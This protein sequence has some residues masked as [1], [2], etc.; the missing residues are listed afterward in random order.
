M[1]RK[2][3]RV[4]TRRLTVDGNEGQNYSQAESNLREEE[5]EELLAPKHLLPFGLGGIGPQLPLYRR[6]AKRMMVT[7]I[8]RL[9]KRV[10]FVEEL[11]DEIFAADGVLAA[12]DNVGNVDI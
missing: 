7:K 9:Q 8:I 4:P 11:V 3:D 6:A 10:K 12:N 5:V 1:F 2:K